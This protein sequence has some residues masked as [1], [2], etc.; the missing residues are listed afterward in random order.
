MTT[1]WWPRLLG[2]SAIWGSA[3]LFI[4]VAIDEMSP[5]TV[6]FARVALGTVVLVPA[7]AARGALAPLR[8]RVRAIV[9]LA[10]SMIVAPFLLIAGGQTW[11]T[12]SLAGILVATTPIFTALL[13]PFIDRD[14]RS[15]GAAGFGIAI[16]IVGVALL[17]GIDLGGE[18]LALLG[19]AMVVLGSLG[20]ALAGFYLKHRLS[21]LPPVGAAAGTQ[22]VATVALLPLFLLTLPDRLP[23]LQAVGALAALG[24]VATGLA[25]FLF[26]TLIGE[27]GPARAS[28]VTYL[29]PG[30][31]VVYGV[32]LLDEALGATTI[33]GLVLI[34]A[35]SWLAGRGGG[36]DE[37]V[38]AAGAGAA[39][40]TRPTA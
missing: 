40:A 12:S 16:G 33:A 2:L 7:A 31:A 25:M 9:P 32:L 17:L 27:V 4:E 24:F 11:I 5:V 37:E 35:G 14:E 1:R 30:F 26:Y 34:L 15:R 29:A 6:V 18:G 36:R 10:V 19:G 39:P 28:L 20:Y 13:A 38:V 23:S 8:G 21:D 22:L 3:Y